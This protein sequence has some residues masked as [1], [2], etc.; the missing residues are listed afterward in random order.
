MEQVWGFLQATGT[1]LGAWVA[2]AVVLAAAWVVFVGRR[3]AGDPR[4]VA[5]AAEVDGGAHASEQSEG[6]QETPRPSERRGE[7]GGRRWYDAPG[8]VSRDR[9]W[10]VVVLLG[11]PSVAERTGAFVNLSARSIDWAA[12]LEEA[13][14]WAAEDRLL[15]FTA[16][17]LAS[18]STHSPTEP[19]AGPLPVQQQKPVMDDEVAER[20]QSA[21]DV[22]RG[23]V[24]HLVTLVQTG[25]LSPPLRS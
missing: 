25:R 24:D 2:L 17:E 10:A 7:G 14:G 19:G 8:W 15:V 4:R 5:L 18:S 13:S 3:K 22:R 21:L 12:L 9:A 16:Y 1:V 6:F 11:A 20:L 23:R